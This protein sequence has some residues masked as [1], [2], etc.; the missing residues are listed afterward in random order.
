MMGS[1]NL[2]GAGL[3][4]LQAE[5]IRV[6]IG[7]L[8]SIPLPSQARKPLTFQVVIRMPISSQSPGWYPVDLLTKSITTSACC[9]EMK[10]FTGTCTATPISIAPLSL[11]CEAS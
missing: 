4:F 1:L 5:H 11:H 9:M 6:Q 3:D 8:L 7:M 10:V 2:L